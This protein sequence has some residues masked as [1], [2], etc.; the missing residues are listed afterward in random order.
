[1][2]HFSVVRRNGYIVPA[3][4]VAVYNIVLLR[5]STASVALVA[6]EVSV[7]VYFLFR[8]NIEKY[9]CWL[10]I[11]LASSVEF[12]VL[13]SNDESDL[14]YNFKNARL[15]GWNLGLVFVLLPFVMIVLS[16]LASGNTALRRKRTE[17]SFVLLMFVALMADGIVMGLLNIVMNDNG[18]RGI[19]NYLGVFLG[20]AY[21]GIWPVMLF[22]LAYFALTRSKTHG[23]E[24]EKAL[25]AM[26]FAN[27]TAPIIPAFMG[28]IGSYGSFGYMLV[29]SSALFS[30]FIILFPAYPK[31]RASVAIFIGL[32]VLGAIVPMA[33]FGFVS[34]KHIVIM[35]L[36]PVI[37]V[38]VQLR[39]GARIGKIALFVAVFGLV[40]YL[41]FNSMLDSPGTTLFGNKFAEVLGLGQM[42]SA[43]WQGSMG[44]SSRFRV[45]EAINVWRE[46]ESNPWQV[47]LGKGYM[48]SVRDYIGGFGWKSSGTFPLEQFDNGTYYSL[49]EF[50][51]YIL[52]FGALGLGVWLGVLVLSLKH[53][54]K[55]PWIAIGGFWFLLLFGFSQTI[56]IVGVISL[57]YGLF[58]VDCGVSAEEGRL[59]GEGLGV[60]SAVPER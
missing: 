27:C 39:N 34:G 12:Q 14:I 42:G 10:L 8:M 23:E 17:L 58:L 31:Y 16:T 43:D 25:I 52:K 32:F 60:P 55:N 47:L 13:V 15:F 18:I 7:L 45:F 26:L 6:V 11:F 59:G 30:A 28:V 50:A 29:S 46:Y 20:E 38:V 4:L 5:D 9:L 21:L 49:H 48:G 1:M 53:I 35:F 41:A 57:A 2:G 24:L 40:L 36:V 44:P 33:L 54:S 56:S 3:Y 51:G 22:V 37:Y 19:P